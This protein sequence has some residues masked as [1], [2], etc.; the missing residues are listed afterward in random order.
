MNIIFHYN[1]TLPNWLARQLRQ[2]KFNM[3]P[4]V[5]LYIVLF[6]VILV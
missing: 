6:M 2:M 5:G 1:N 4:A 3:W